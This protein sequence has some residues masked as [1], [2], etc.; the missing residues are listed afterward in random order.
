M[1]MALEQID[2]IDPEE[3]LKTSPED[4]TDYFVGGFV[5]EV[6]VLQ[7]DATTQDVHEVDIDVSQDLGRDVRNRSHPR[8]VKGTSV[9]LHVPF[10]G[11]A[12][13]LRLEASTRSLNPPAAEIGEGELVFWYELIELD[14]E[15]VKIHFE[16]ELDKVKQGLAWADVD[17]ARFNDDLAPSVRSRIDTRRAKHLAD[18]E[19]SK[20]L[21]FP[22]RTRKDTPRTYLLP[23]TR[24]KTAIRR[25]K[26]SSDEPFAPEPELAVEEY[27]SILSILSSMVHVIERSPEAFK[28][29]KEEH[30][31]FQFL[32]QLN[33]HYEGQA[34]GETFNFQGK[35]DILIR[36][37]DK[38]VFIAE[39]KFW[40][41]PRK[42]LRTVDQLLGY[43]SWRDTKTAIVIFNRGGSLTN[44]LAKIP[45]TM[46]EHPNF[47]RSLPIAGETSFRYVFAHKDDPEREL[48]V[49]V[50]VFEV[51]T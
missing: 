28:E 49:S 16:R 43:A 39:C 44:V 15:V 7:Y 14:A 1:E 34:T 29:M 31:R 42:L 18:R 37:D 5:A 47:K 11:D 3:L 22:L 20:S 27:E 40:D 9:G 13:I 6:P 50:L 36:A 26:P 33:G 24:K 38:N 48:L 25:P 35:T 21:G 45:S 2:R 41:G 32:V 12:V 46:Q 8:Y 17:V 23:V 10:L 30:L 4:L 19:L 51:P